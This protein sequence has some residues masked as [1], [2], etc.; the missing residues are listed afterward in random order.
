MELRITGD[1]AVADVGFLVAP[2]A[3]GRGYAPAALRAL[4]DWGFQA[5]G[6]ER[7]EW[8]AYV[9]NDASHRV[10]QK[11]GFRVEGTVRAG[12]PHR[13][14]RRDCWLGAILAS[15]AAAEPARVTAR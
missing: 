10:A 14:E 7:I 3:R 15:D 5:L 1:P 6:L 12:I 13:G 2:R 9:G 11:A 4:C 8:R